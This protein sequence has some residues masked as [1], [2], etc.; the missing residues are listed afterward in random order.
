MRLFPGIRP[1]DL[2]ARDGKLKPAPRTPNAV[3]S[4]TDPATDAA[5]YIAPLACHG[6]SEGTWT[7]LV[8]LVRALPGVE[9]VTRADGYLHAECSSKLLGFIDDLECLLDRG[10]DVIHV[11]SAAR[12]GR[13]DFGVNRAR[14]ETLRTQLSARS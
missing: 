1:S 9:I 4:Q 8:Q 11:R 7:R 2:G 3:S 5:H 10:V 14:I 13:S 6:D 12:L